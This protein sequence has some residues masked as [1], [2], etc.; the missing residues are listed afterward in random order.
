M[1]TAEPRESVS[2]RLNRELNELLQELRVA[3][4]GILLLVAF[5][6]VIPFSSRFADVT[7]FQRVVYY[8]TFVTAGSA[9]VVIVAPV[10]YHRLVFRRR[11]KESL[12]IRGNVMMI[13]GMS[14]LALAILGVLV[15]ITDFLFSFTLAVIMGVLYLG[16]V[17]LLWYGLPLHS[18][19]AA[20]RGGV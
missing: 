7:D 18:R 17:V 9:A 6:L 13:L 19:R 1:A 2:A 12:I 20:Q 14:L 3:Q 4:N 11:D 16:G 10:A 8:L 5:L 15:L